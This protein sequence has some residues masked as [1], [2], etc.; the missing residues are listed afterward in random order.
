LHPKDFEILVDLIFRQAGWQR[1]S[2]LGETQKLIDL[3]LLSPVTSER[4]A[5]QVKSKANRAE[6]E[7]YKQKFADMQ[8]YTRCY[9]V[10][11]TP[12]TDL[13]EAKAPTDTIKLLQPKDV[14][15]LAAKYGLADWVID[16]AS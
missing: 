1:V 6:F 10:V 14:A 8:G 15:R 12:S 9:F 4:Y 13:V 3:D 11:H 7:S 2:V 16:K 5:V